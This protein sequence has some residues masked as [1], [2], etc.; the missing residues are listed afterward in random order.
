M[1]SKSVKVIF[2]AIKDKNKI[3][4]VPYTWPFLGSTLELRKNHIQFARNS[5]LNYGRSFRA[6]LNGRLVTI[7]G[8]KSAVEVFKHPDFSFRKS[9]L[10]VI[11]C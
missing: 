11:G 4:I 3:P 8:T 1:Y 6:H 9:K 10:K 7:L 5:T 2:K